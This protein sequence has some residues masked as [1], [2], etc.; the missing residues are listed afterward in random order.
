MVQRAEM[1][2]AVPATAERVRDLRSEVVDPQVVEKAKRRR[3]SA[4]YKL[5]ILEEVDRNPG[6]S[7]AILRREGLYSS[8][9]SSWRRQQQ[10]GALKALSKKRG[11]RGKSAEQL[12]LEKLQRDK[13]RLERELFKAHAIINAQKKLAEILGVDLPK[14]TDFDLD[15]SE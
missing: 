11:P 14:I 4:S 12:Q 15:K 13:A 9:L 5:K 10:E 7:G 8:H 3:F 1:D 2:V 6:G